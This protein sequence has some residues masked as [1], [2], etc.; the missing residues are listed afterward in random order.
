M[1]FNNAIIILA[2]GASERLGRPKQFL[3]YKGKNTRQP[4][5]R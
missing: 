5:G 2:A 3:A 1:P 4:Y